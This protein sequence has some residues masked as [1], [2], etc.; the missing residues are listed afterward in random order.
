M[1]LKR[2]SGI[3]LHIT[4]LPGNYP[5]GD[6][7]PAAYDFIDFLYNSGHKYWQI[8]PLNP[9][10]IAY[11]HSPYSS[12]S[13]FAGNPLLISP[14][15]LQRENLLSKKKH[16]IEISNK[17]NFPEVDGFKKRLLKEAFKNFSKRKDFRLPFDRFCEQHAHWLDDFAFFEICSKK[18]KTRNWSQWPPEIKSRKPSTLEEV[19][20][21]YSKEIEEYKFYQFIFYR[22]W[23]ELKEY[24][25][26]KQVEFFGDIPIYINHESVDCWVNPQVFKLDSEGK[27]LL[28][29]GVPPDYFSET[30]QLW[31]TPVYDWKKL[32]KEN[33]SWWVSRLKQNLFLFDLVRLDHFRGFSASWEVKAGE[34]TAAKGNWNKNPGAA[35]FRKVKEEIPEMPFI[36]EDLGSIDKPVQ[37]L[38][39]KF[40]FPGMKVLQFAFGNHIASNPYIPFNY[41]SNNVVYTGTHDNNTSRGWYRETS[42]EIRQQIYRYCGIRPNLKN[43]HLILHRIALQSVADIAVIPMQ[44][45]LGLGEEAIMNKPGNSSDNNWTWRLTDSE[46]QQIETGKLKE[47][48]Q[49]FGRSAAESFEN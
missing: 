39:R 6:L 19:E 22:Q 1:Q 23:K 34:S 10:D 11:R 45:I 37:D 14:E 41:S 43:I 38:I 18:Y 26:K 32:Q 9:T 4:S 8:L 31:G 29:S 20:K 49:V 3:L 25:H 35:F 12:Y 21:K 16:N 5:I 2:S 7:G 24:A 28:I 17:V 46:F 27:P 30:G 36:A 44:D 47:L 33:F 15:I 42:K 40:G 48:N 13:A